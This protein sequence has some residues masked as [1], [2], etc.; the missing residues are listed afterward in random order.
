M[1]ELMNTHNT[2]A[3]TQENTVFIDSLDSLTVSDIVPPN[4]KKNKKKGVS[5]SKFS[6]LLIVFLCFSV[7]GKKD[8]ACFKRIHPSALARNTKFGVKIR[9]RMRDHV[10]SQRHFHSSLFF[11]T[12]AYIVPLMGE[13]SK[14]LRKK[15][16][17]PLSLCYTEANGSYS[18]N[19]LRRI[20]P[21]GS[22][23]KETKMNT[24]RHT[25]FHRHRALH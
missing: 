10:T 1:S 20:P 2:P 5:F 23:S 24:V 4:R 25:W 13:K 8:D 15:L 3:N 17:F 22:D 9:F 12:Y 19:T 21:S 14:Y 11:L 16:D 6:R 18:R 7:F